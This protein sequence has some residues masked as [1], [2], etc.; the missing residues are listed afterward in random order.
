MNG[1]IKLSDFIESDIYLY[2]HVHALSHNI[3]L[4]R[5]INFKN[6]MIDES[7][8]HFV[9]TGSFLNF[10]SSYGETKGYSP[11]K[12]GMPTIWLNEKRSDVQVEM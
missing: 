11:L 1:C 3:Q 9:L 4:Y 12:K 2:G 6:K 5:K 7:E 8:R 10:D